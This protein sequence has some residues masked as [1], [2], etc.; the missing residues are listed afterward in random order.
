MRQR[1]TPD[2]HARSAA[3]DGGWSMGPHRSDEV[4]C[5]ATVQGAAQDR[6]EPVSARRT[7][8]LRHLVNFTLQR[9]AM[10]VPGATTLR[11]FLHRL[12][13]V[14]IHGTVFIGEDVMIESEH[15][16][17]VEIGDGSAIAM[18]SIVF[19][20]FKG[21]GR[22][23]IGEHVHIAPNSVIGAFKGETLVI[24]DGAAVGISSVVRKSVPPGIFVAGAPARAKMRISVPY[25][26]DGSYEEFRDGMVRLSAEERRTLDEA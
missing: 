21:C 14:K 22:V 1:R 7:G 9:I 15:P 13:G 20:H 18:R 19:A 24:G 16:E 10:G 25:T 11:P 5:G 3:L 6:A 8:P 26:L 23:I 12:R 2:A 17:L 4:A